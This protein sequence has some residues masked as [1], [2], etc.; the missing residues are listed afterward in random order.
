MS[1]QDTD[2]STGIHTRINDTTR[3]SSAWRTYSNENFKTRR[4]ET[5]LWE[6]EKIKEEFDTLSTADAVVNL[7]LSIVERL[8]GEG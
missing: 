5:F 1:Y 6:D 4:W 2:I 3:I 7:H 8:R